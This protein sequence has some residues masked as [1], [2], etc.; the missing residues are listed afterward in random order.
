[1]VSKGNILSELLLDV[2]KHLRKDI[3][4]VCFPLYE[5]CILKEMEKTHLSKIIILLAVWPIC[6]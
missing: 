4:G 3:H 5:N 2:I 6:P 1:M